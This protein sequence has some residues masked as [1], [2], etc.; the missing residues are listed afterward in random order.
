MEIL[1]AERIT[2]EEIREAMRHKARGLSHAETY[3]AMGI[4]LKRLENI[5]C[6]AGDEGI[7]SL[8]SDWSHILHAPR[9]GAKS[10]NAPNQSNQTS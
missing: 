1:M 4:T 10:A 8:W 6:K 7:R 3:R 5:M 9:F 2:I